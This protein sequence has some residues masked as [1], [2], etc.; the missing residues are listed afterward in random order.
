[1]NKVAV[2]GININ[3]VKVGSGPKPV[4]CLPGALGSIWSDFKPQVEHLDKSKLTVIVWDPPGYGKS[5]PPNREFPEDFFERDATW[6]VKFMQALSI[7]KFS[8][9]GWSDGGITA[10]I[11]A[12]KY[13]NNVDKMVVWGSN[14]YIIEEEVKIYESM[15]DISKWS[16]R[17]KAPLIKLYGEDGL[18][19][20]WSS[21]TDTLIGMYKNRGGN[22]CKD[23]LPKI[24]CPT[25][26][27]H[28]KKDAMVASEH[29]EFLH[30]NIKESRLANYLTMSSFKSYCI[31]T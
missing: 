27:V 10:L 25:L 15:R 1:E 14:A 17:M 16:D 5:R 31:F 24:T 3:Y 11:L 6:A 7:N 12:A 20:M 9:L 29:P 8:M 19:T 26:I 21:W 13:P 18:A 2:N 22:I 28:G 23:C 4:L 30:K